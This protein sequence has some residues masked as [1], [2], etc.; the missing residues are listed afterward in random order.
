MKEITKYK[1]EYCGFVYDD[2]EKCADC[3]SNHQIPVEI[4]DFIHH[5]GQTT[6]SKY[7]HSVVIKFQNGASIVYKKG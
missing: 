7:P 3:E 4:A 5:Q 6:C 2:K 1:C